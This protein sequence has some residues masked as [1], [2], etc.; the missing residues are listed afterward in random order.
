MRYS[1]VKKL[2]FKEDTQEGAGWESDIAVKTEGEREEAMQMSKGKAS[3]QALRQKHACRIQGWWGNQAVGTEYKGQGEE[4]WR[5][6]PEQS[7]SWG[8]NLLSYIGPHA[9]GASQVVL[10]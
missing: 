4:S 10:V 7:A 1:G 2:Q 8:C 6:K 5:M 3:V 9:H